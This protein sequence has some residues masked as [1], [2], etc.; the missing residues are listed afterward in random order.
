MLSTGHNKRRA[1]Q[2]Q[3]FRTFGASDLVL[4]KVTNTVVAD[5]IRCDTVAPVPCALRHARHGAQT[6]FAQTRCLFGRA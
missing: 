1:Q 4:A 3:G 2:V 6:R 5:A